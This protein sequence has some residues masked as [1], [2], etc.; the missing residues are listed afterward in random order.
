MPEKYWGPGLHPLLQCPQL[1]VSGLGVDRAVLR[2]VV[3]HQHRAEEVG[4]ALKLGAH[5]TA[6]AGHLLSCADDPG[7]GPV[8]SASIPVG[9]DRVACLPRRAHRCWAGTLLA[10]CL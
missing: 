6:E 4:T 3:S 5:T 10:G 1:T 2:A 9:R 7:H 8:G